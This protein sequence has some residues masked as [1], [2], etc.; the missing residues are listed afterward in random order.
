MINQ[1]FKRGKEKKARS[2]SKRKEKTSF[3]YYAL[4]HKYGFP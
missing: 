2:S 4:S 3:W 1:Q